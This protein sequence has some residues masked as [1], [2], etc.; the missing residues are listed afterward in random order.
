[1][2]KKIMT[3]AFL[4]FALN[5]AAFPVVLGKTKNFTNAKN[6]KSSGEDSFIVLKGGWFLGKR[7]FTVKPG[8]DYRINAEICSTISDGKKRNFSIGFMG[9]DAGGRIITVQNVNAFAETG[10]LLAAEAKAGDRLILIKDGSGW[11]KNGGCVAW[12]VDLSGKLRDLPNFNITGTIKSLRQTSAG[13]EVQLSTP[14]RKKLTAGTPVRQHGPGWSFS[15]SDSARA[16]SSL[17]TVSHIVKSGSYKGNSR[18]IMLCGT[19]KL[20]PLFTAGAGIE[21][22][23]IRIEEVAKK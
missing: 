17:K 19:K 18:N 15:S 23:N 22:R 6:L 12:D 20:M 21:V 7:C 1:M 16:E 5:L 3:A 13:W 4:F 10:T 9:V 8:M 11:R 14:L 2:K